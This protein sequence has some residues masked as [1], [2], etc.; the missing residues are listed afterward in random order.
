MFG[1]KYQIVRNAI[2]HHQQITGFYHG[3]LRKLCPHALGHTC[4]KPQ[5]LFYQFGGESNH[6][7]IIPDSPNNWR[8]M[9]LDEL[10]ITDVTSGEWHTA[11]NHSRP[12]HCVHH[13]DV[14][15]QY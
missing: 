10:Q 11:H 4:G 13:I 5:A 15:V 2:L 6:G 9:E 3:R 14:E 7:P 8:C 12:Q 1:D